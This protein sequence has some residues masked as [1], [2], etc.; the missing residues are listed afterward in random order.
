MIVMGLMAILATTVAVED[1]GGDSGS[2]YDCG[3][4]RVVAV[5]MVVLCLIM[6]G[7]R[8]STV[9]FHVL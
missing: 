4:S 8:F 5:T 3:G 9:D 2:G 7:K 1:G 6:S